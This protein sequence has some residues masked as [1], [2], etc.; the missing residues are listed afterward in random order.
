[1]RTAVFSIISPNYAAYAS[2]LMESLERHQDGWER[3]VLY[4]DDRLLPD[5]RSDLFTPVPLRALE[6]PDERRFCFRYSLLELNTAVKPWGFAYLFRLGFQRV[7]YLDPDVFVYSPL[8]E[9]DA[10][11]REALLTLTPHL[12]GRAPDGGDNET[13]RSILHAGT[14]NLGFLAVSRQPALGDFI[15]WWQE[16]LEFQCLVD[17]EHGLFVDQKWIDL[18]PA[19]FPGVRI[20]RH[21]GYNVAYWNLRQRALS[22]NGTAA[23]VN[24]QP[25][26][27]F[28]FSGLNP[29]QPDLVSIHDT[30][31]VDEVGDVRCLIDLYVAGLRAAGHDTFRNAHYPFDR[32]SDGRPVTPAARRAYRES[33]ALQNAAGSDPFART[34]LFCK[35][36]NERRP[37]GLNIAGYISRD[38]GVGETARLS[39]YACDSVGIVSHMIDVDD[40]GAQSQ[41][42]A[43]RATVYHINADETSGLRKQLSS[44]FETSAYNIGYWAWELPEFP[45]EWIGAARLLNEIW[46]GS[47]F[48][49]GAISRKVSIPVV[50]M[51]HG[52][53]VTDIEPC[54]PEE[55]GIPAGVFTF[56]C[57]F[58]LDSVV[59][60]KNPLASVAAFRLAFG[61]DGRVALLVKAARAAAYPAEFAELKEHVSGMRN[62]HL[63]DRML[64]RPR[65]NGLLAACGGVVSLHRS[66]GFGLILAEA[67]SLGKPVVATGWSGNMEFMNAS[68]SAPVDYELVTLDRSYHC[69]QAGEQWAQPDVDHAAHLLKRV[70]HNM[71]W[72]RRISERARHT[73]ESQFSP[74]SA[75]TRYRQRLEYLGLMKE[76]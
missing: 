28:H 60:R 3:F 76:Y 49:Q 63:T 21:D 18:A 54:P 34:D 71:E 22:V 23:L 41:Q 29:D 5:T 68:N 2:V 39:R 52:I 25:L 20:F 69:Y 24:G 62:V 35:Y 12:T 31:R 66:E 59:H 51:P 8:T 40:P 30:L 64:S 32:F 74:V 37:V 15:E 55:F 38:S 26:R 70:L 53:S 48:I 46:A 42:A 17:L 73:I 4:V 65:V 72:R 67:M 27:F 1:M 10:V 9:L 14:Y 16:K 44:V 7:I 36:T 56:L 50:H 13:Q 19:L 47:A 45:D 6:L 33:A 75:G 61:D 43:F 57:M 58:D 11:S